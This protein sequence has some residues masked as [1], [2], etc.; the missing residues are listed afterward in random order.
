M[1]LTTS[2]IKTVLKLVWP[3]KKEI[4][5]SNILHIKVKVK[6]LLPTNRNTENYEEF[7]KSCAKSALLEGIDN[8]VNLNDDE[9]YEMAQE[10]CKEVLSTIGS[11]E[12]KVLSVLQ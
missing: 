3:K 6:R 12:N 1:K 5:K 9:A 7:T 2:Q 8:V 10:L 4:T 11:E